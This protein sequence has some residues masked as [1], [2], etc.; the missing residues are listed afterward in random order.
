[1]RLKKKGPADFDHDDH[2]GYNPDEIL[3]DEPGLPDELVCE[4]GAKMVR[5]GDGYTCPV[6]HPDFEQPGEIE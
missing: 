2:S 4:C 1:M 6:C 5:T 3:A